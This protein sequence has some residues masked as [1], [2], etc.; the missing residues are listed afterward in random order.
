MPSLLGTAQFG[1]TS[2]FMTKNGDLVFTIYQ[3]FPPFT[4]SGDD[5][6]FG[7]SN[8]DYTITDGT[9]VL[10]TDYE[11]ITG[12]PLTGTLNFSGELHKT[13]TIATLADGSTNETVICTLTNAS[14]SLIPSEDVGT[15]TIMEPTNGIIYF[16][17][18]LGSDANPG[19]LASP[20]QTWG[21]LEASLVSAEPGDAFLFKRGE[22]FIT[23]SRVYPRGTLGGGLGGNRV[24]VGCYGDLADPKPTIDKSGTNLHI[25]FINEA[26]QLHNVCI[27]D[28]HITTTSAVGSRPTRGIQMGNTT[29][30]NLITDIRIERCEINNLH[31]GIS[32]KY[33]EDGR[34][35]FNHVHNNYVILTGESG[36]SVG[37]GTSSATRCHYEYNLVELNGKGVRNGQPNAALDW[38]LYMSHSHDCKTRWNVMRN[39]PNIDKFRGDTDYEIRGNI[40]T[41]GDHTG[42]GGG[43]SYGGI[44]QVA[45]D[46]VYAQNYKHGRRRLFTVGEGSGSPGWV[47]GE[48]MDGFVCYSNILHNEGDNQFSA[49]FE[50][51]D[52]SS[53]NVKILNNLFISTTIINCVDIRASNHI[54][55]SFKNNIVLRQTVGD[56]GD[57]ILRLSAAGAANIDL[58]NNVYFNNGPALLAQIDGVNYATLALYK[59]AYPALEA[60]SVESD[61][62]L[63]D[64]DNYDYTLVA[65]SP[66][67]RAGL[68]LSADVPFDFYG[69]ASPALMNIGPILETITMA[70]EF[71]VTTGT[72]E[73]GSNFVYKPGDQ[74]DIEITADDDTSPTEQTKTKTITVA[75]T[76]EFTNEFTFEF[77]G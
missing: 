1:V 26:G 52:S 23:G 65:N 41:G 76:S 22:T 56:A 46:V 47:D 35:R 73:A 28:L 59:A 6:V 63:V 48:M 31:S 20:K 36:T 57:F 2:P 4:M 50:V 45:T 30:S 10:D 49:L 60:G 5:I 13:V 70:N 8:V 54:T 34:A 42:G 75:I 58:E 33:S 16:D 77:T 7:N 32:F 61:P 9:G 38:Q 19:T 12:Q 72:L 37:M 39:G 69:N 68:N 44:Y 17:Q 27:Q 74:A 40:F 62:L 51:Q 3:R 53:K 24:V 55:H 15:G 64:V 67:W 14:G 66:A 29:N 11:V 71:K 25:Q 21:A 18:T 43:G